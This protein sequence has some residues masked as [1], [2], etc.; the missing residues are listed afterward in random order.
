VF[1]RSFNWR[2]GFPFHQFYYRQTFRFIRKHHHPESGAGFH[3]RLVQIGT[4]YYLIYGDFQ[5]QG[6]PVKHQRPFHVLDRYAKV[7]EAHS[8]SLLF[9]VYR[10]P[11]SA[12]LQTGSTLRSDRVHRSEVHGV[13]IASISMGSPLDGSLLRVMASFEHTPSHTP[14]PIHFISLTTAVSL[15]SSRVMAL[16]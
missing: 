15:P 11:A 1:G 6:V 2:T 7:I 16:N 14:Q 4:G 10:F 5:T 9:R 12:S 13:H 8:K 3:Y